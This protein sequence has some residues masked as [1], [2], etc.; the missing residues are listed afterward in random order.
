[1]KARKRCPVKI[2]KYYIITLTILLLRNITLL[3]LSLIETFRIS[4]VKFKY[5]ANVNIILYEKNTKID[6]SLLK[7]RYEL[8][9][10]KE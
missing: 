10:V 9:K 7:A 3:L 1:M 6:L 2:R 8:N 5:P 4:R